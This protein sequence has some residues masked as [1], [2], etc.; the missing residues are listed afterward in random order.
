MLLNVVLFRVG[1]GLRMVERTVCVLDPQRRSPHEFVF[2][3][4]R[5]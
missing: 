3:T 2:D 1:L 5:A 4:E